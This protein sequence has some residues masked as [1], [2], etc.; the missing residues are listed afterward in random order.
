MMWQNQNGRRVVSYATIQK[1]DFENNVILMQSNEKNRFEKFSKDFTIYIRGNTRSILFKQQQ[2]RLNAN[3]LAI[4]IPSEVRLYEQRNIPRFNPSSKAEVEVHFE[5]KVGVGNGSD[6]NFSAK[7]I[8]I[9]QQGLCLEFMQHQSKFFYEEDSLKIIQLNN[10]VFDD[11]LSAQI[12]YVT[13]L[14][15]GADRMRMGVKFDQELTQAQLA[16][17]VKA[18]FLA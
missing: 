10:I 8:N 13:K 12:V 7:V 11:K 5:K 6:K 3:K 14:K 9:S 2:C 16:K 4:T 17:I 18:Y 1:I 15:S